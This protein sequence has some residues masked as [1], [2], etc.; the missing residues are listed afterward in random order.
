V[1]VDALQP[2]AR[3]THH[4]QQPIRALRQLDITAVDVSC[5]DGGSYIALLV[6]G[7]RDR[8]T[9]RTNPADAHHYWY[10]CGQ[11]P[12]HPAHGTDE[13]GE[14]AEKLQ[15]RLTPVSR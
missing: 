9:C 7:I 10:W 4:L 1:L 6:S 2:H 11:E 12:L 5:P 14:A 15:Q 3:V 8:V 13:A